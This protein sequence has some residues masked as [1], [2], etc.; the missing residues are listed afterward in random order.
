VHAAGSNVRRSRN[1][2]LFRAAARAVHRGKRLL[3]RRSWSTAY[4]ASASS[5]PVHSERMARSA[6]AGV[7]GFVIW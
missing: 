3:L 5:R 1:S 7:D 2:R 6:T 4:L